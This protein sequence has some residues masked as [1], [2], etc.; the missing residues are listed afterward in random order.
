MVATTPPAVSKIK[1]RPS[2]A[3]TVIE[4]LTPNKA[5]PS[6]RKAR[7]ENAT[8]GTVRPSSPRKLTAIPSNRAKSIAGVA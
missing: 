4:T 5:T 6:R 2:P 7:A 3:S 1:G 8:P